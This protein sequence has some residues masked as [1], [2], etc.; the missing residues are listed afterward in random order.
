MSLEINVMK[1]KCCI[2]KKEYNPKRFMGRKSALA[3]CGHTACY[4][5]F[6][7]ARVDYNEDDEALY[8]CPI[9]ECGEDFERDDIVE[10][11]D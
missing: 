9:A 5:C 1:D 8:E 7:D 2:C 11:H 10:L 6:R 3:T 4:G